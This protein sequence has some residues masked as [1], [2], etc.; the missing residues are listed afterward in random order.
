MNQRQYENAVRSLVFKA[1]IVPLFILVG[2]VVAGSIIG[3]NLN[4]PNQFSS[5]FA[6]AGGLPIVGYYYYRLWRKHIES[7]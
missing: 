5:I 3:A 1:I 7:K 6:A 2:M 4:L